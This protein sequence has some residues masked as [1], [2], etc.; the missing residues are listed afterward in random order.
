MTE[1][2]EPTDAELLSIEYAYAESVGLTVVPS[3]SWV[4]VS[5]PRC[6][7]SLWLP[8]KPWHPASA[9]SWLAAFVGKH[10]R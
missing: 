4:A 6:T 5:C 3:G 8:V 10:E 9:A 1:P 2:A 7:A